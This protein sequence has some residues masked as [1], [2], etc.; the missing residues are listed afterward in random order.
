MEEFTPTQESKIL[1]QALKKENVRFAHWKGN[2]HLQKS[3]E[4]RS[5]IEILIDPEHRT[6]FEFVMRKVNFIKTR[7]PTWLSYPDAEDWIGFDKKTGNLLHLDTLYAIVTGVKFAKQLYLP[8]HKELFEESIIDQETGWPIPRPEFEAIILLIRI[9]ARM[10][11]N[12]RRKKRPDIPKRRILEVSNLLRA[13]KTDTLLRICERLKLETCDNFI[14]GVETIKSEYS[15]DEVLRLSKCFYGQVKKYYRKPWITTVFRSYYYKFYLRV[16]SRFSRF[17]APMSLKKKVVSGG[18]VIAVIG[19][20]GS[21]KST[22]SRDVVNWLT[23]KIDTHY[24]YLGKMPFI[25]SYGK[26]LLSPGYLLYQDNK[27]A[28]IFRRVSGD[29]YHIFLAKQK[30]KML[31]LA[32]KMSRNGSVILCDRYPQK[33]ILGMNDG[34]KLQ[35]NKTSKN[36]LK[37]L[38]L[39]EKIAGLEPDVVF[40]LQV[41]PEVAVQRKPNHDIEAIRRKCQNINKITFSSA[42]VIDIDASKPYSEVLLQIKNEIWKSLS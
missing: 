26:I 17:F 9:R 22:L 11:L 37:E 33:D 40:R 14:V 19:S 30:I 1:L 2:S 34:P 25:K 29:R 4:G 3:L 7:N 24:F 18:K 39:F 21:G 41:T 12:K 28:R 32:R 5:D 23:L 20:D 36:A 42:K 13:S 10:S 27:L 35:Y 31:Q 16:T 8:W 6:T 15:S 38:R